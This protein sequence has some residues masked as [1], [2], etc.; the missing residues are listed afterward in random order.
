MSTT[1][2]H[3]QLTPTVWWICHL[4]SRRPSTLP[5]QHSVAS[6]TRTLF[7]GSP[8]D[9][10]QSLLTR[11]ASDTDGFVIAQDAYTDANL[12]SGRSR[13]KYLMRV[14][15]ALNTS[16]CRSRRRVDHCHLHF[17]LLSP[18]LASS[19]SCLVWH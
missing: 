5:V 10:F 16:C 17:F 2:D 8:R 14:M 9:T 15:N 12:R 19:Q 4:S 18:S 6:G 7:A 13:D 1:R 3:S 11:S